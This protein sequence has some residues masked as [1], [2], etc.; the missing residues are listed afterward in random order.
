MGVSVYRVFASCLFLLHFLCFLFSGMPLIFLCPQAAFPGRGFAGIFRDSR[1]AFVTTMAGLYVY[2][3]DVRRDA[4]V[5][6]YDAGG[7]AVTDP[8]CMP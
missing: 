1:Y 5:A 4:V 6:A 3:C 2:N 7:R 8:V